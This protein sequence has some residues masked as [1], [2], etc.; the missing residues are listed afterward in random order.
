MCMETDVYFLNDKISLNYCVMIFLVFS[1]FFFTL[2][3]PKMDFLTKGTY[4]KVKVY[5]EL[6]YTL[7]L[8]KLIL[9]ISYFKNIIQCNYNWI[10][11]DFMVLSGKGEQLLKCK[12]M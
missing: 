8:Y 5:F 9:F 1:L 6:R 2:I 4:F 10:L 7:H 12:L 11:T 3:A